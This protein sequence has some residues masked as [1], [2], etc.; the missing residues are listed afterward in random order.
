LATTRG[1]GDGHVA[2]GNQEGQKFKVDVLQVRSDE[3]R[4]MGGFQINVQVDK[5]KQAFIEA[6]SAN[7]GVVPISGSRNA[8]REPLA[9]V[10]ERQLEF[11]P[12]QPVDSRNSLPDAT[13]S[14]G[15][16]RDRRESNSRVVLAKIIPTSSI[17]LRLV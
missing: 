3:R 7:A 6:G 4:V 13:T 12:G 1:A 14:G 5:A 17:P 10:L 11:L 16:R 9:P 8:E 15:I 2:G